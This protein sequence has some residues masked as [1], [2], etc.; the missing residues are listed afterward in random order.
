MKKFIFL[1]IMAVAV[2]FSSCDKKSGSE[3]MI[4]TQSLPGCVAFIT[5]AATSATSVRGGIG[6]TI[7]L[8]YTQATAKVVINSLTT[9]DGTTYPSLTFDNLKFSADESGW[10]TL[11]SPTVI[12]DAGSFAK[13]PVIDNFKVRLLQRNFGGSYAPALMVSFALDGKYEVTST[14]SIQYLAGK[15]ITSSKMSEPFESTTT[16]YGFKID[17]DTKKLTVAVSNA[18][19]ISA[20][21]SINFQ[22]QDL[23]YTFTGSG[24][25]F[26]A[27]AITPVIG[28]APND[29]F[30]ISELN[31]NFDFV[32]GLKMSYKCDPATVPGVTFNVQV[33]STFF[34]VYSSMD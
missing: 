8:N 2:L 26:N 16:V 13:V 20:M 5:D 31:G 23:D 24:I 21:P 12:P 1:A 29:K 17:A 4:T 14:T 28:T 7:E 33:I 6:Y 32:N 22:L 3:D 18:S 15:T 30:P 27:D 34:D 11:S 25:S 10:Y 19:F 9:P